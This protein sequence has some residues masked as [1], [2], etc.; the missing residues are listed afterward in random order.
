M[1]PELPQS[2]LLPDLEAS[3]EKRMNE[4]ALSE[5]INMLTN[6]KRFG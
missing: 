1:L 4:A 6:K 2:A 3:D 5:K